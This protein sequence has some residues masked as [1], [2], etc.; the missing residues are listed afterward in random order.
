M[1]N[2]TNEIKPINLGRMRGMV[3]INPIGSYAG[4]F[5]YFVKDD[6]IEY[7]RGTRSS[8][9]FSLTL[10]SGNVIYTPQTKY[11]GYVYIWG[12]FPQ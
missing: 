7:I 1:G 3:M 8:I 9:P 12:M 2:N 10:E 4:Y 11:G 5:E 6:S